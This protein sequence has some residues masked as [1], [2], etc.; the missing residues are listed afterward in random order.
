MNNKPSPQ[1]FVANNADEVLFLCMTQH[2]LLQVLLLFE[3]RVTSF[4]V[5]FERTLLTMYIL[6]VNLQLSSSREG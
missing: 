6:D 1:T 4:V 3:R 5:A 2:M